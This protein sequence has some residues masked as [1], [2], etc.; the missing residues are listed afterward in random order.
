MKKKAIVTTTEEL[1]A[2]KIASSLV[3]KHRLINNVLLANNRKFSANN[4]ENVR[5]QALRCELP[6]NILTM[7]R[8]LA[9]FLSHTNKKDEVDVK[10]S[11]KFRDRVYFY[12]NKFYGRRCIIFGRNLRIP[13]T[14]RSDFS[15][16]IVPNNMVS[17]AIYICIHLPL[18]IH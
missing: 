13:V 2:I 17:T 7:Q 16:F 8:D 3:E 6:P 1:V 12:K 10:V 11:A 15:K 5:L 4:I 9:R 14:H 18:Y